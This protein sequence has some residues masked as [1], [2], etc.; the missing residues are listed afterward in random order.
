MSARG[1]ECLGG[2][3]GASVGGAA[4]RAPA[5]APVAKAPP[6]RAPPPAAKVMGVAK[7]SRTFTFLEYRN[8]YDI[9]NELKFNPELS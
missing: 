1:G 8:N 2:V 5:A 6:S 7:P 9:I 4:R 3:G